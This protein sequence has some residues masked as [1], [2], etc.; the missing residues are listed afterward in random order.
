MIATMKKLFLFIVACVFG[1]SA[2]AQTKSADQ[3]R[4]YINPGHGSW[5]PNDR[6]M[7]TIPYPNLADTGMPDTCGFYES[8]TNLWKALKLGETLEKMGVK[9]DNIMYSRTKNGPYPYIKD[10]ADE[11]LYNRPL[12]EI[13]AEVDANNMDIFI[14]IHSNAA[15]DGTN[16]NYPLILYRG[17]DDSAYVAGSI[18]M[19]KAVW[20]THWMDVLDP[21]SY[22]SKTSMNIRGDV[23]FYGSQSARTDANGNKLYGYLGVLKHNTPGFL[24]EGY[25]H[26]YQPARHRALNQDYCGQE[27]I[28]IARG[29]CNYFGLKAESTGYIM[30][31][32]KDMH[33]K[34]AN[35]LFHY[36]PNTNDQWKPL[37][38]ATVA[39]LK[40]G[41]Q[42]STYQ[43]DTL[44]NGIFVF[45]DL[46]PGSY[47]LD[48][49][50]DG[51]KAITEGYNTP[52]TVT[53]NE[54][55]YTK[56]LL[57]A[58]NYAPPAVVYK[59]YPDP[60]QEAYVTVPSEF[61]FK[62]S[63]ATY[64]L[65]GTIKRA[66]VRG[67]STVVLTD[68]NGTPKLYLI[69]NKTNLLEKELS[70][71]GLV[72]GEEGDK[73]FYSQL[74]DI[75]FTADAKL[76]GINS[77]RCQFS[78]DQ[79]DEGYTRGT[80]RFYKWDNLDA[81]PTEWASTQNSANFYRAD[82]GK[83]LAVSGESSD[84]YLVTTGTTSASSLG[85]RLLVFNIV[86]NQIASSTFTENT[87]AG[88][89]F[90]LVL[91]GTDPQLTV[92][93]LADDHYVYD[94]SL[95]L[96]F[97]FKPAAA[98][99]TDSEVT[100]RF[101][102]N[103]GS[104]IG[105]AG[106]GISF[107]KYGGHALMAAPFVA[108][109]AVG[110]LRLFDV[111]N[112]LDKPQLV[113]TVTTT[114]DDPVSVA[115]GSDAAPFMASGAKVSGTD[116]I[117]YLMVNGSITTFTTE[118]VDQPKVKGI[119]A[120]GLT[121][122]RNSDDSYT[123]TFEANA[124]PQN[125]ELIFTTAE[126]VEVGTVAVLDA[127]EGK[128]EVTLS[129][130]Q[131]PGEKVRLNWAVRLKGDAIGNIVR[132]N[133]LD[134]TTTYSAKPNFVTV[135]NYPET[136]HFGHIYMYNRVGNSSANNGLYD[137]TPAWQRVNNS[138]YNG[139]SNALVSPYRIG[140]DSEGKIYMSD[141]AD[142]D[143]SG[144]YYAS[145]NNLAG[146]FEPFFLG[147]H[148]EDGTVTNSNGD[149]VV[150]ST[151]CVTISGTGS[152][153]KMYV[154]MEDKG[155]DVAVYNIG[156]E[157]GSLMT[158]WSAAPNQ[159]LSVNGLE[160]NTNCNVVV[161]PDGGA[162]VSQIRNSGNNSQAVPSLIYISKDGE[163]TFNSGTPAFQQ[164]LNG[165][166]GGGFA[167]SND[168]KILVINDATGILQFFD[169]TW[170]GSTPTLTPKYSYVADAVADNNYIYQMAFDYAGNLICA[171]GNLG[172][173]SMP[174]DN[175]ETTTPAKKS[176]TVDKSEPTSVQTVETTVELNLSPNPT[177]GLLYISASEAVKSVKVYSVSGSLVLQ[178]RGGNTIDMSSLP[179][180][181]YLVKVNSYKAVRIIKK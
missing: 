5:G 10:G 96:P 83:T 118:N 57:E 158:S 143:H 7:A 11:E 156:N 127:V 136:D 132:L 9:H 104:E 23:T 88:G 134:E 24:I 128:N 72:K 119:M 71:E 30:G 170:T 63:T 78:D 129:Q 117:L 153:A 49:K 85:T 174:T 50:A 64:T 15:S 66:I 81:I 121:S 147:T 82:M 59:N 163:I 8:N 110:G 17:V 122:Q 90:N 28:R 4:I 135:N 154:V 115:N 54:T 140:I 40:D 123:F 58:E 1:L 126:G 175:N 149:V 51:Y 35:T 70:T 68:S 165:S 34:M 145:P 65:D 168:G 46:S 69:N 89:T 47:T 77:V 36:A 53:A 179:D 113:R 97:E 166:G 141:W 52:I 95:T 37:N 146:N 139:G 60:A 13:C 42:V 62:S 21:Q 133:P 44:Y 39:L 169:L 99:N 55:A 130:D 151:P 29:M 16:T 173:Y 25:F 2:V 43:V 157:D 155:N 114:L 56:V 106:K 142:G 162:W 160:L 76:I 79:V 61:D 161:G 181:I 27:G 32:V 26:T 125:A 80:L 22:Y 74:N 14:S 87:L 107:F 6:P 148:A 131:I 100:G 159:I 111:T 31:T 18:E 144:I 103:A 73:G 94:G 20:P 41:K 38:G 102:E 93:P 109:G 150:T 172:I 48:I 138:P 3:V 171:G 120:Y 101:A 12:S 105:V 176:L 75:A 45:E 67:D 33:E 92:S 116:L 178:S 137:Y 164:V 91:N 84:C 180:G 19:G 167:V 124:K 112:G 86:D 177:Q 152:N 108:D 98:N